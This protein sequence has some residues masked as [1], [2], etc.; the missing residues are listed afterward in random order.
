MVVD[1]ADHMQKVKDYFVDEYLS[2]RTPNPCV[3]CNKEVKFKPFL[4]YV[5]KLQADYFATGH[6]A[7]VEH[8]ENGHILKKA[9]DEKT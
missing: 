8:T 3:V 1:Y 5:E 2:G 6:Y 9:K 4:E 7:V